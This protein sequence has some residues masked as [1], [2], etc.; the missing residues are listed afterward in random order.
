LIPSQTKLKTDLKTNRRENVDT[1]ETDAPVAGFV[2]VVNFSTHISSLFVS[3]NALHFRRTSLFLAHFRLRLVDAHFII[4]ITGF[5]S[6]LP[7]EHQLYTDKMTFDITPKKVFPDSTVS[8]DEMEPSSVKKILAEIVALTRHMEASKQEIAA[9]TRHLTANT[10]EIAANE[11]EL[12]QEMEAM[13][14]EMKANT[15]EIAANKTELKQEIAANKTEHKQEFVAITRKLEAMD[16][17]L[18]SIGHEAQ[19]H[20]AEHYSW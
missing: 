16:T 10:Q 3:L 1:N 20:A 6:L 14:Q 8:D 19:R 5:V 13:K 12:K 17:K 18:T 11:A 15:Q 9:L 7:D 4:H 2:S